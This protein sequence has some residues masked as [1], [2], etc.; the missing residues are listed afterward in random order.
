M[1]QKTP[2]LAFLFLFSSYAGKTQM[3]FFQHYYLL[4]KNEP[5]QINRI[6]QDNA[7]FIWY[8][9]DKGL[10]Q[11]NG[12][13]YKRY[14]RTDS[15]PDEHVTAIAQDSLGRIWTGHQDGS[16]AFLQHG[17]VH[18]FDPPEGTA[19]RPVSDI[20]FDRKGRLWF[21]TL[22][23]GL[24]YYLDDRIFRLDEM[25]GMPDIFVYDLSEDPEGNIWGGTD[26]GI[27]ICKLEGG[28]PA[29]SVLD[30]D[31][32]LPDNIVK[33]I[34]HLPDGSVLVATEDAGILSYDIQSRSFAPLI[35]RSWT[36][37]SVVDF[38]VQHNK[39][40]IATAR[41]GLLH[42]DLQTGLLRNYS[43]LP[44]YSLPAVS[45]L[46]NDREGNLWAGT[47]SGVVRSAGA[48][49]E[50][51][52]SFEAAE[53]PDILAVAADRNNDLWFS[54]SEGLFKRS[55]DA[56]GRVKVTRPLENSPLRQYTVISLYT[57]EKG[58]V[59]AGLYGEGV[60]RIDPATAGTR[61][62]NKE[63]RN[64]NVLS[65]TGKDN[66][67]WLATLGGAER[68]TIT[69]GRFEFKNF[70]RHNGLS[71][72]FI[73]EVFIDSKYRVW[74]GTDGK[75]VDMLQGTSMG[76][77]ENGL[78][79][80]VIYGFA[81]DGRGEIWLNVQGNGIYRFNDGSFAP[82]N[83]GARLR[84][85][86]ASSIASDRFGNILVAHEAG[87][88]VINTSTKN[89]RYYG[90]E[91]GIRDRQP[92]LNAISKDKFGNVYIGTD[93]GIIRYAMEDTVF[94]Q[95][96]VVFIDQLRVFDQPV[97]LVKTPV[98]DY[99][100]NSVTISFHGFW[101]QNTPGLQYRYRM[102]NFD[103]GWI[104]TVN[105]AV[106]Y[107]RLP[108]GDY[109][110]R[111]K[112]SDNE[113]FSQVREASVN[114]SISPPFWTTTPF[115]LSTA[116]FFGLMAFSFIKF[117]ERQLKMD[118][119]ILERKVEE[120]TLEIQ[121]KTEEI[122]AQNEEIMAQAEEIKGINENLEM[123]VKQRTEELQKKNKA[124]E[125][126]AFIN[127]HKLRG[128]LASILGLI[129][130]IGKTSLDA[131]ARVINQHLQQS[132]EELDEI[133]RSITIAIERSEK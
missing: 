5:V 128:P 10:F 38:S 82:L 3:P 87:I 112:G 23:D 105:N 102:D 84:S 35:R 83:T 72:D 1:T 65:I 19:T 36:F 67:I 131:E 15:L 31:D 101:F 114:F 41:S 81:E 18:R 8:G 89:I 94:Q 107:S 9:T 42:Y 129:N 16:I 126:Y 27:V 12:R 2:L 52:E 14:D 132:A 119:L 103:D 98:L 116:A 93:Q 79:S 34:T 6:F 123:L 90:E 115:Y 30:Y 120:R 111:I 28:K 125:E 26:G 117:R 118:N 70:S 54:T 4:K 100:E 56:Q 21:S 75:G 69:E 11:F 20:L 68:I 13:L 17:I 45:A 25:E 48:G 106:T 76:H 99:D 63:L 71:S 95:H 133:V 77:F 60:V 88:D 46:L 108:P 122:Q 121:R 50:F 86:D 91:A 7:G 33:K 127:A 61:Y 64:G 62:F 96:P 85:S 110:F 73:Y 57:D 37:G 78:P 24:Y 104:S 29:L 43:A 59:W 109:T 32:G 51:I 55:I 97:D 22:N 74:F 49:L 58:F 44:G 66:V 92:T 39:V 47:K 80:K 130:L 113:D 40:W 53:K 124:L